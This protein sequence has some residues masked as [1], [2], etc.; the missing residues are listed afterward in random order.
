MLCAALDAL[1][2]ALEALWANGASRFT[3]ALASAAVRLVH[4]SLP[5]ALGQPE[6]RL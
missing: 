1:S 5:R 4:D 2:H 6:Q 3:D